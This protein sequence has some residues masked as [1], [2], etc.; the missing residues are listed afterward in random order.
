MLALRFTGFAAHAVVTE[1]TSYID[2]LRGLQLLIQLC[3]LLFGLQDVLLMNLS[4]GR[5]FFAAVS[6]TQ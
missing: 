2:G 3:A 4:I 1:D 5:L 6:Q